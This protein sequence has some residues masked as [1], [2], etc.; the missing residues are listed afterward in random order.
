MTDDRLCLKVPH[1]ELNSMSIEQFYTGFHQPPELEVVNDIH[2]QIT[3]LRK[4]Y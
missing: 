4:D 1:S 3:F 2:K